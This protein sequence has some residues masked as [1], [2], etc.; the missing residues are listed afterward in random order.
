M[1]VKAKLNEPIKAADEIEN[2]VFCEFILIDIIFFK[3]KTID[4]YKNEMASALTNPLITFII[5][6]MFSFSKA[7]TEKNAPNI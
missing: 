7:N 4:Q 2:F 1:S 6:P 5:K 3:T